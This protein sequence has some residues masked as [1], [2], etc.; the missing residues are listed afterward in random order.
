MEPSSWLPNP[1]LLVGEGGSDVEGER[2][3]LFL[4]SVPGTANWSISNYNVTERECGKELRNIKTSKNQAQLNEWQ[5]KRNE[6]RNER[7]VEHPNQKTEERKKHGSG[8]KTSYIQRS[9]HVRL[10]NVSLTGEGRAEGSTLG[11]RKR[12]FQTTARF[13][14][15]AEAFRP[16]P[17]RLARHISV[18]LRIFLTKRIS[19]RRGSSCELA[20]EVESGAG[21]SGPRCSIWNWIGLNGRRYVALDLG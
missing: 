18:F 2:R 8:R 16:C 4:L 14:V 5:P 7:Q 11:P 13:R 10:C 17:R 1:S 21:P 15:P 20:V 6:Q 19:T 3:G 12:I 9:A